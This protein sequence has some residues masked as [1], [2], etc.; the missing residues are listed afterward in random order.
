MQRHAGRYA[1]SVR[2]RG[3]ANIYFDFSQT[4]QP[5]P[6]EATNEAYQNKLVL[7]I[8]QTIKSICAK[9]QTVVDNKRRE[10]INEQR[11]NGSNTY[12]DNGKAELLSEDE[13]C[14]HVRSRGDGEMRDSAVRL[15]TLT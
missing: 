1:A 5:L 14:S 11:K 10:F 8:F 2:S 3:D 9:A 4:P 13:T 6:K 12:D 15:V 7:L